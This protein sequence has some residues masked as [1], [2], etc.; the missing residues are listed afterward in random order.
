MFQ[1][2]DVITINSQMELKEIPAAAYKNRMIKSTDGACVLPQM[3][4]IVKTIQIL[5]KKCVLLTQFWYF[6]DRLVY[7][8]FQ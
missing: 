6:F 8:I 3:G 7:Q 1:E 4:S 5:D 2:V